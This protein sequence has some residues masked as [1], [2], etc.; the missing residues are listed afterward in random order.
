MC[1]SHKGG[2][3]Q[4]SPHL[5]WYITQDS[6]VPRSLFEV[7]CFWKKEIR[8]PVTKKDKLWIEHS[9]LSLCQLFDPIY[10]DSL[11]TILPIEFYHD[12]HFTG[13]EED[14]QYIF[15]KLISI[16]RLDAWEIQLLFFTNKSTI[17]SEGIAATPSENLKGTWNSSSA[18]FIDNG[19]GH[20]EIWIELELLTDQTALTAILAHQLTQYKLLTEYI[21]EQDNLT[22]A[23]ATIAF[24]FGIFMGNSYFKFEQWTG[25]SHQ[26]WQISKSGYLPEQVI[27]YAMAWLAHYRREDISWKLQLN[28]TMKKY[29]EQSYYYIERNKESMK[30]VME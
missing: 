18:K 16:M 15:E 21:I 1:I 17:F 23:I 2:C 24:G 20:R 30:W 6:P 5:D 22:T 3:G 7:L 27:A 25:N 26:G 4:M 14:A 29:F 28:K 13:I 12:R 11:T 8:C 19:L 9:L 10:F